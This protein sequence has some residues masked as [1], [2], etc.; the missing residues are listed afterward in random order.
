MNNKNKRPN[1]NIPTSVIL[2]YIVSERDKWRDMYYFA[3]DK[4]I[5]SDKELKGLQKQ[6][7]RYQQA[8]NEQG[9]F[10][11]QEQ[12]NAVKA[13][14]KKLS[15]EVAKL[16]RENSEMI[17]KVIQAEKKLEK[18]KTLIEKVKYVIEK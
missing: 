13:R 1:D 4:C 17:Y 18:P 5:K 15:E 11:S 3:K 10:I 12:Y 9:K 8:R 16:R 6:I 7:T 14:N 2:K